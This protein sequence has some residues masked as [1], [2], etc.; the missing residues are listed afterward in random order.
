MSSLCKDLFVK[1]PMCPTITIESTN[2]N[3][4]LKTSGC[5]HAKSLQLCLTLCDPTHCSPPGSS[6][7]GILQTRV[8]GWVAMPSSRGSCRPRDRTQVS[9]ISCIG[10]QDS[11]PLSHRGCPFFL[12][13]FYEKL[14]SVYYVTDI[15]TVRSAHQMV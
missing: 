11:L 6:V 4:F 9:S 7:H 13:L 14:I 5:L 8:L 10:S 2:I 15:H 12:L 1:L 3:I